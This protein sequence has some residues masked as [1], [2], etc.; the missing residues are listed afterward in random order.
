[1]IGHYG[2]GKSHFLAWLTRRLEAGAWCDYP[3]RPVPISLLHYAAEDTLEQIVKQVVI[4]ALG[5]DVA[6][7]PDTNRQALWQ[8]IAVQ[9]A[10]AG[11]FLLVDELSE[12]LRSKADAR[13]FNEDLR[14]L[15][16]L[17]EWMSDYP[18]WLIASLQEHIE[19][20][21]EIEYALYRKIRDRYQ[22]RFLLS[23][24]HVK[25]LISR[26]ILVKE[27]GYEA[28]V[29]RL[30]QTLQRAFPNS[31]VDFSTLREIYPIH[32]VTLALL[33][34]VRDR[35]SQARGMVSF[36]MGQLGGVAERGIAPFLEQAW[37]RLVSPDTIVD[38]F[39]DLFEVQPEF[40]ALAQRVLPYYR[41][42]L[43]R[44]FET[45][46][47][48]KLADRVL[49]LLVL[50]HLSPA[51]EVLQAQEAA[52]WLLHKV[53]SIDPERNLQVIGRL[54]DTLADR[55]AYVVRAD[56]GYLLDLGED[57]ADTVQR[58][59]E[60]G[61]RDLAEPDTV[62][63]ESLL[64]VLADA[65]LNPLRFERGS[66]QRRQV[67]WQFH[68]R[69]GYVFLG[70][71]PAPDPPA[72]GL[73]IGLPWG[74][75]PAGRRC[76]RFEPRPMEMSS[77]LRELCVLLRL[78]DQAVSQSQAAKI[79]D[80][81]AQLAPLFVNG[82]RQAYLEGD[83]YDTHG[84][85]LTALREGHTRK[86]GDWLRAL[87]LAVFRFH[88][89][90]FET[91]APG[92]GPLSHEAYRQLMNFVRENDIEQADAPEYVRLI[93]EAY[94]LPMKLMVRKGRGYAMH[95]KLDQHELVQLIRPMLA[96]EPSP[97][98]I[99][100]TLAAP[101]YGLVPDQIHLLLLLLLIQGEIDIKRAKTSLRES[102]ESLPTPRHY[103]RI[104]EGKA[105]SQQQLVSFAKLCDGVGVAFPKQANVTGQ[106]RAAAAFKKYALK[107]IDFFG[108]F[109]QRLDAFDDV[110][111]LQERVK[112]HLGQWQ[113]MRKG[114]HELAAV[115]QFLFQLEQ[116]VPLF[117]DSHHELRQLPEKLERLMSEL[118]RFIHLFK[119]PGLAELAG[120]GLRNGIDALGEPPSFAEADA[121]EE[122][123][124]AASQLY[125]GHVRDYQT[126]HEMYW[127]ANAGLTADQPL[128]AVA[129]GGQ[130][131]LRDEIEG[132][133]RLKNEL[134]SKRCRR[135]AALAFQPLC[136]CGFDGKT[137]PFSEL[138]QQYERR[139]GALLEQVTR[140]FAQDRVRRGVA[141]YQDKALEAPLA[142]SAY[143]E[144]RAPFPDIQ[145]VALFD[146]H[147]AGVALV[148]TVPLAEL[149]SLLVGR[150]WQTPALMQ[151]MQQYLAPFE[152]RYQFQA[153]PV[154][155]STGD[156][157]ALLL[158]C[159]EAALRQGRAMPPV[160]SLE[161]RA[162]V[163]DKV[164]PGWV[165]QKSLAALEHLDLGDA[166]IDRVCAMALDGLV[167]VP[168]PAKKTA[169]ADSALLAA[170][171]WLLFP[172]ASLPAAEVGER[173]ALLYRVHRRFKRVTPAAW[174]AALDRLAHIELD[175]TPPALRAVLTEQQDA[176]WLVFDCLGT[177]LLPVLLPILTRHFSR[178]K[179][180]R[181]AFALT[182]TTTTTSAFYDELV[183]HAPGQR[184]QKIDVIDQRVHLAD[185][186]F[187]AL[188]KRV[189]AEVEVALT[190]LAP[191]EGD[192]PLLIFADHG[193]RCREDGGGFGHGGA[194]TLERLIPLMTFEPDA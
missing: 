168:E 172:P 38:Y 43:P 178:G 98:Q 165:L 110:V 85:K 104:V 82:V 17:G 124:S 120:A 57:A 14:F 52:W 106:K 135:I 69:V 145:E 19:R 108:A 36:V 44:L 34:E 126:K 190:G 185:D 31:S 10:G 115:Q 181:L 51:R 132:L 41:K 147:L 188:E 8:Q 55:G 13:A 66:W 171:Q 166:I 28:E 100:E 46:A 45:E 156:N 86:T 35:F 47:R 94:W 175:G 177:P 18:V 113:A 63:F 9:L 87:L 117:L 37:G 5:L 170:L 22:L 179:K 102:Y 81:I 6:T 192:R 163:A 3:V 116:S 23:P 32:P 149:Q 152:P 133:A 134:E 29:T 153:E 27:T 20:T 96:H 40:L 184:H 65:E 142:T 194:T 180:P 193:F 53:S 141:E 39:A 92:Y 77:G 59:I 33:E 161:A 25:D 191:W 186:D 62:I 167:R 68:E 49:K 61:L 84:D 140:F 137:A 90:Q 88:F 30:V 121:L 48:Q 169:D 158:W 54:L 70:G 78:H 2:S 16:F 150:T 154:R 173:A 103:D 155:Q 130:L 4:E 109:L 139:H 131:G 160:F 72:V 93:R 164:R 123:L 125:E 79:K 136:D 119:H 182:G 176:R 144:E 127:R 162:A 183:T 174:S 64:P 138:I 99:Y 189:A 107:Q 143:L 26:R 60:R 42:H 83:L 91:Y 111:D 12:F 89:P 151:T 73:Q 80:R 24:A 75:S 118:R 50:V 95:P 74:P 157:E 105:L 112:N 129:H 76:F 67:V 15:Q 146:Q 21:G 114:D 97:N 11:L 122:W 159:L 187:A 1:M 128:P 148:E 56:G 58:D 71:G 101:I 7:L